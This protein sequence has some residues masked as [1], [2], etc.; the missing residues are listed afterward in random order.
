MREWITNDTKHFADNLQFGGVK[1]GSIEHYIV[2]IYNDIVSGSELSEKSL[3]ILYAVDYSKAF[4]LFH[5]EKVIETLILAGVRKELIMLLVSYLSHRSM[6]VR[7]NEVYSDEIIVNG[8][9]GQ[10]T[11][12]IIIIFM[13][14]TSS[15]ILNVSTPLYK[16]IDDMTGTETR[17][18]ED[19]VNEDNT[20]EQSRLETIE[21]IMDIESFANKVG[22]RLNPNKTKCMLFNFTKQEIDLNLVHPTTN[23]PLN[24]V[25]EMKL[26]GIT[27]TNDLKTF[28]NTEIKYKKAMCRLYILRRLKEY[29]S[30]LRTLTNIYKSCIRSILDFG[31]NATSPL[32]TR[33]EI[34]MLESVQRIATIIITGNKYLTYEQRLELCELVKIE[35]RH[36][37][38]FKKFCKKCENNERL[39]GW[40]RKPK[41]NHDMS[42]RKERKYFYPICKTS[43]ALNNPLY[44]MLRFLNDEQN[45]KLSFSGREN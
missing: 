45:F 29:T 30:D 16:Y 40:F 13:L 44:T 14:L 32:M 4:N 5:R 37:E 9:L 6:L 33:K 41:R 7:W 21:A 42:S 1:N 2:N 19:I 12:V 26:L 36:T 17:K 22:M 28:K 24:T 27:I 39:K 8:G 25:K 18:L 10:G 23:I 34:T 11:I 38:L 3:T 15:L 43:R 20:V 35:D 31:S